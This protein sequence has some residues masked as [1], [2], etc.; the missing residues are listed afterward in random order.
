MNE[1][2]S[3]LKVNEALK[4]ALETT[5]INVIIEL[6]K[7]PNPLVRKKCLVQMCPC[8]VKEEIDKF[9]ERIFEMI[10]DPDPNVRGQVLH[11]LCDGSPKNMEFKVYE[12]LDKFNRDSDPEIRRKAHKVLS[13]YNGTGKWNIL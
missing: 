5:D 9:W 12:A 6:S 1:N 8:R 7:H 3:K 13:H 2:L 10:N 4:L 11:T